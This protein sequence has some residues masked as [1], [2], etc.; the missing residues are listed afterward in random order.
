MVPDA[1]ALPF[2]HLQTIRETAA[3]CIRVN[4]HATE[5]KAVVHSPL[6]PFALRTFRSRVGY[7]RI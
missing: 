2:P 7:L 3:Y 5:S 6:E 1:K 4:P